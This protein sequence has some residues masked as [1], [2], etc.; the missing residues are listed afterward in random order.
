MRKS[1]VD[2]PTHHWSVIYV[3]VK[4]AGLRVLIFSCKV[5]CVVRRSQ[6]LTSLLLTIWKKSLYFPICLFTYRVN[7]LG[8]GNSFWA[9]LVFLNLFPV[10][11]DAGRLL[12]CVLAGIGLPT[13][14]LHVVILNSINA[15]SDWYFLS[16]FLSANAITTV[17][18]SRLGE[19]WV[20]WVS[21]EFGFITLSDS[22]SMGSS[23][24]P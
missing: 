4:I 5:N 7:R 19:E 1:F 11:R 2:V 9:H 6:I 3:Y 20:L 18:L 13:D 22:V 16:E 21:E 10:E 14:R 17:H 24:M 8:L 12:Y 23:I 15:V